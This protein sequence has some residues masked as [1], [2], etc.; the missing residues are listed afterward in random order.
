MSIA[1]WSGRITFLSRRF[2]VFWPR[3]GALPAPFITH[4]T[5]SASPTTGKRTLR[6]QSPMYSMTWI[7]RTKDSRLLATWSSDMP[8]IHRV[9]LQHG[10]LAIVDVETR[11]WL[12]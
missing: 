7:P 2:L 6:L 4:V 11:A 5:L 8:L 9:I 1:D 12:A 3:S 10:A